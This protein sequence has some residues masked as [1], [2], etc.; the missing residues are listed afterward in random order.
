MNNN[1]L[2]RANMKKTLLPILV[3]YVTLDIYFFTYTDRMQH[4]R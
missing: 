1:A 3:P 2:G 4:E